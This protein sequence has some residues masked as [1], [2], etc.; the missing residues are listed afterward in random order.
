MSIQTTVTARRRLAVRLLAIPLAAASALPAAAQQGGP[1]PALVRSYDSVKSERRLY[2]RDYERQLQAAFDAGVAGDLAKREEAEKMLRAALGDLAQ[3]SPQELAGRI[4]MRGSADAVNFDMRDAALHLAMLWKVTGDGTHAQRAAALLARFAQAIP[5]W[6][7]WSPYYG[8]QSTKK[9]LSQ[10][11]PKTFQSEFSAGLWGD[12]IYQ[13]L[14]MGTPLAQAWSILRPS[15]ALQQIGAEQA[16]RAMLDLHVATQRKYNPGCDFS[17]MDAF[18]IRGFM[19]FGRLL[20]D[21]EL[22]HEGVRHLQNMYRVGFFPDGW[23]HEGATSYHLDLQN[24]LRAIARDMLR[25]Y[26]DPPGFRSK[27]DGSR[28]DNLDLR[29]LVAA[30]SRRAD[31]V[32][33]R[34]TLP[35]QTLMAVHD[36]TWPQLG[37]Q[38]AKPPTRSFLFGAMGQG[39]LVLGKDDNATLATLHWSGSGSHSHRDALNL[40]LWAKGTEAI[41][42]TQYH[43]IQGSDST[44]EWH[45]STPGH[46]TVVVDGLDQGHDGK[47]GSRL[48]KPQPLDAIPGVPDWPWRWTTCAA[49][50]FGTLRLFSTDF[51]E[52]QVVEA[53]AERAYDSV[54]PVKL[55]R[56]TI[57][58]VRI[59]DQDSYVVDIFRVRGGGTFDYMLHSCLQ[60][61]QKVKVALALQPM[62]GT[63]F[64]N[65]RNLRSATTGDTW[66]AAFELSNGVNM[67]TFMA[68]APQTQVVVGDGPAMRRVGSAPFVAVRRKGPETVFAAVHHVVKGAVPRVQGIELLP[69]T[70]AG[71]VAL[72][73][74]VGDR[75]DTVISCEEREQ[76][77]TVDGR[78]EVRARFAHLS[79]GAGGRGGWAYMVD[80]DL[81][82]TPRGSIEGEVSW[83]G[84]VER[85]L[86]A[87]EDEHRENNGFVVDGAPPPGRSLEGAA[88]I[89]DLAQQ[90]TW[91]YRLAAVAKEGDLTVLQTQDEP[92]FS[93]KDGRIKQ[94]FFP[95]WGFSGTAT[96]RIP[97]F[98]LARPDERGGRSLVQ[99]RDAKFTPKT[100]GK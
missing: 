3:R 54:A 52:V 93:V 5:Q 94:L 45:T 60:Y 55:Y 77:H 46:V 13:D 25:G 33:Q 82:R 90:M 34:M 84:T 69:T 11:D 72:R 51:R 64:G 96:W 28:Y 56:R 42:E 86:R 76:A 91:G 30:P 70:G 21:P 4:T 22:V 48:R 26:T 67:L 19:D 85:T 32:T 47:L 41:S 98:A 9:A 40:N 58:L 43:P 87:E 15:G 63:L 20:P 74:K 59:D 14:I 81:L 27:V 75:I 95:C 71:C 31:I 66:L 88:V 79:E 97:G 18:Q 50:D 16:V 38:S 57:A 8:E 99:S 39:T 62:P 2:L 61:E 37:P 6:P 78:I 10:S 35:D 100:Q 7:I 29:E 24:G 68:G 49:Q 36:T 83:S 80:G 17:N 53:D 1:D 65:L 23:W 44:R 89:V 92:G 12:W 73:V